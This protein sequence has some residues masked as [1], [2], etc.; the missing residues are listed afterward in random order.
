ML[1]FLG[2]NRQNVVALHCLDGRSNT[3]MLF[4]GIVLVARVFG[5]HREALALFNAKR[6]EPMLSYGQRN[7]IKQ[8]E[9]AL[10]GGKR[11]VELT[12]QPVTVTSVILEPVPLFTKVGVCTVLS[13]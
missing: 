1:E 5:S 2:Q 4:V 6:C 13:L 12:K 7:V 8:L 9:R 3:A 10:K 11:E